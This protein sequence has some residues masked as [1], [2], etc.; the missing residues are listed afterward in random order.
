MGCGSNEV[1]ECILLIWSMV[2]I[3][4]ADELVVDA[5]FLRHYAIVYDFDGLI[6]CVVGIYCS[7]LTRQYVSF[8]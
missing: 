1:L 4:A 6:L 8:R 3:R 7:G 2:R 5:V